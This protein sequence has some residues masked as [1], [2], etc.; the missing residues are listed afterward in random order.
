MTARSPDKQPNHEGEKRPP[1]ILVYSAAVAINLAWALSYPISK[2]VIT[3]CTPIALSFWRMIIGGTLLLVFVRRRD[4]PRS[5]RVADLAA[6]AFMGLVGFALAT[7]LQYLGTALTLAANVSLLIGL[8]PVVIVAMAALLLGEPFPWKS[9]FGLV[10]AVSGVVLVSVDPATLDL[11]SSQYLWGNI[12]VLLSILGYASYTIVGKRLVHRWS[13][14]AMTAIPLLVGAVATVPVLAL[15][16]RGTRQ[17]LITGASEAWGVA[18]I[19]IFATALAYAGWNW[20]LK[21]MP[22][23]RLSYSLY[24]QPLA[25]ALF[26][27]WLLGER[28]SPS[29]FL[30]ATLVMGAIALGS[31]SDGNS[32]PL[33]Q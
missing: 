33:G 14:S 30:G 29:Y 24:L 3:E 13:A 32:K 8:E 22:A 19:A 15:D 11:L 10:L 1:A 23:S 6:I 27:Y 5:P 25:G 16:S 31:S 18:F 20:L 26:S 4:V 2:R 9:R 21:W 28:L 17:L 7:A 12:L